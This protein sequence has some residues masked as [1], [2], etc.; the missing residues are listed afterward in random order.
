[1]KGNKTI[2]LMF[3]CFLLVFASSFSNLNF[4]FAQN[5]KES[6]TG[7]NLQTQKFCVFCGK[8]IE[9]DA[10]ICIHCGEK[11]PEEVSEKKSLL[12]EQPLLTKEQ[13]LKKPV[14][15][16]PG[17]S[18]RENVSSYYLIGGILSLVLILSVVFLFVRKQKRVDTGTIIRSPEEDGVKKYEFKREI[19][20]RGNMGVV[21]EAVNKK[22]KKKVAIKKMREELKINLREKEKFLQEART[23][24]QLHHPNI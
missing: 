23:V 17:K 2:N 18:F 1:M 16:P 10:K 20:P 15:L 11:Q 13:E 14:S 6:N 22:L 9:K 5:I 8:S 7:G 4:C 24:A 19:L 21:Y 3:F 12:L